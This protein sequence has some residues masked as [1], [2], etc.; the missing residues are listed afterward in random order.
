M[1][2][3]LTARERVQALLDDPERVSAEQ[4]AV[5]L[6]DRDVFALACPGSGKTR[7][8]GLRLAWACVDGLGRRA[9]ATSYT[10]I[11]V[12]E[13]QR[14]AAEAGVAIGP[15]HFVGTLHSFLLRYVVYPFGHLE[16]GCQGCPRIVMDTRR[17]AVDVD[18]VRVVAG[19]AGIPVWD[20]HFR[21][22]GSFFV[23]VP[24]TITIGEEEVLRRGAARASALKTELFQRGLMSPSDAMY[25]AMRVLEQ[26]PAIAEAVVNR[27]DEMIV[28]EVQDTS[29]LQ[30]AC[31]EILKQHA[32]NSVVLLGDIDQ[33]IY[34][35]MGA[36]PEAC[37]EFADRHHLRRLPLTSNFRSSQVICDTTVA[38]SS[39]HDA[40]TAAGQAAEF[41]AQP[42]LFVYRPLAPGE[43]VNFFMRRVQEL[44][45]DRSRVAVL[46]RTISFASRVSGSASANAT[47]AV[48]AIGEA[49]AVHQAGRTLTR[50]SIQNLEEALAEM[51]WG[52][53]SLRARTPEERAALRGQA[54]A[55]LELLPELAGNLGAWIGGA[56]A[57][58]MAALQPL[59]ADPA[60]APSRRV[61]SIPGATGIDAATAFQVSDDDPTKARTIHSAKGES[62]SA[63]LLLAQRPAGGRDYAREWVS[64][65][66]GGP[67]TEETRVAYVAIT[68]PQRYL[69]IGLPLGTPEDVIAAFTG[70]G[71]TLLAPDVT[72][73]GVP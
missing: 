30:L 61:R 20:F 68:R 73:I 53:A 35:W 65:L 62:H 59:A 15:E 49:A 6:A 27:F 58:V 50:R 39:R 66:L 36:T 60:I 29:D 54:M 43:A 9:A 40:D 11:A 42:E 12:E 13:M 51:A 33:A 1:A 71:L 18:E 72:G 56:R 7:T 52:E 26:Q 48:L 4:R 45:L 46:V 67:W 41:P 8:V 28:D 64:H 10:N 21:A 17:S 2:V 31:L 32:L 37:E 63:T 44:G 34:G 69:A 16:M 5:V 3:L 22:N 47:R 24:Q 19:A 38:F 23:D 55:L 25:I 57:A 70:S 14:A